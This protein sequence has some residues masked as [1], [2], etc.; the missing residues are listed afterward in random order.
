MPVPVGH[1]RDIIRCNLR[2]EIHALANK[3]LNPRGDDQQL[4]TQ[5]M[6]RANVLYQELYT[7][8]KVKETKDV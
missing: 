2:L 3:L 7:V 5:L 8:A 4:L 6:D 1:E